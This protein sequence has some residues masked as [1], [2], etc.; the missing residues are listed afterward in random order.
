[1]GHGAVLGCLHAVGLL[2]GRCSWL[3]TAT[4][5][6][7]GCRRAISRCTATRVGLTLYRLSCLDGSLGPKLQA[8]R[9]DE[10]AGP[11]DARSLRRQRH[12]GSARCA[13]GGASCAA[14]AAAGRLQ[15]G[16]VALPPR[17]TAR[18]A[19]LFAA[20]PGPQLPPPA[21]RVLQHWPANVTAA[22]LLPTSARPSPPTSVPGSADAYRTVGS[23]GAALVSSSTKQVV[24]SKLQGWATAGVTLEHRLDE[25]CFLTGASTAGWCD[26][27]PPKPGTAQRSASL[28]EGSLMGHAFRSRQAGRS[29][30]Q[31]A[32]RRPWE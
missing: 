26:V 20:V 10:G 14:R 1:M 18:P 24:C 7:K 31:A 32:R 15:P 8:F 23:L 13:W 28:R 25:R 2:W 12:A 27:W 29:G 4:Y 22:T 5:S 30:E 9:R 19:R 21:A 11:Q 3:G 16:R 17:C 6:R